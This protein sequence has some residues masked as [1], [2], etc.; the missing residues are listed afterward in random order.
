M[1][2]QR[3]PRFQSTTERCLK[4]D[5]SASSVLRGHAFMQNLRGEAC[6]CRESHP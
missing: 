6:G 5:R 2:A 1:P 3:T 4:R